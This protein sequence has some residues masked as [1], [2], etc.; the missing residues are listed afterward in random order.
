MVKGGQRLEP[1]HLKC[2]ARNAPKTKKY[3]RDTAKNN[4]R[5]N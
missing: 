1:V 5:P 2:K 3:I 4:S